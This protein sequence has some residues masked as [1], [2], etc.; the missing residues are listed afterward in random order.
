MLGGQSLRAKPAGALQWRI[1]GLGWRLQRHRSFWTESRPSAR[2]ALPLPL[3]CSDTCWLPRG[4]PLGPQF[5]PPKERPPKLLLWV[6]PVQW[7]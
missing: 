2:P 1:Q 5:L 3:D 6:L 7:A 4:D